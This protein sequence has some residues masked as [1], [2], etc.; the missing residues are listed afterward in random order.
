LVPAADAPVGVILMIPLA[1]ADLVLHHIYLVSVDL[2]QT[3]AFYRTA[4]GLTVTREMEFVGNHADQVQG[5]TGARGRAVWGRVP[6]CPI[7]FEIV[8][9][10]LPAYERAT[11]QVARRAGF[12]ML[13]FAVGDVDAM[14]RALSSAGL[15]VDGEV[16]TMP[17]GTRLLFSHDPDGCPI[18]FITL[19]KASA[20]DPP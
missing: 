17:D 5:T 6:G 4:L 14:A 15:P 16:V 20:G 11:G 3:V 8:E 13:S 10:A 7:R 19:P 18:E 12:Q 1:G 9:W 2:E